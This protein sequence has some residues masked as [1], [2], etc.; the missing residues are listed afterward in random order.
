MA[1]ESQDWQKY[2]LKGDIHKSHDEMDSWYGS[3]EGKLSGLAKF[4]LKEC[5]SLDPLH[6]DDLLQEAVRDHEE[7]E[8]RDR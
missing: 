7:A 8:E 3:M 4:L 5:E 1:K 6:A 2:G